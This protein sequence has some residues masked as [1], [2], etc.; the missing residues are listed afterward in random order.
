MAHDD[1]CPPEVRPY[2]VTASSSDGKGRPDPKV[3]VVAATRNDDHGGNQLARTQLFINGLAEQAARFKLPIELVLV[4]WN[5]PSD[6]PPLAEAMSW[7]RSEWFDPKIIV[8]PHEVHEGFPHADGLP[9]FQMIAK[10]VGIRRASAP[11]ALATNIDI[12]LSDELF[13]SFRESLKP[14]A[15]YRVDRLDVEA[16]LDR[17]PL[18]SPAECRALPW[19][20]AHRQD[21]AHYP[22][23][24]RPP[25]FVSARSRLNK[26][27]WDV[28]HGGSLPALFTW[29]CGDFTL[30]SR[31]I[32]GAMRGYPE[33][34]MYSF[35]L[36]S[37]VMV[38]AYEAGVEMV[39]LR[40]PMVA[41]HLEHGKGSGW[42]PEG[43]RHLFDR[44]DAAGV[45]YLTGNRYDSLARGIFAKKKD[46]YPFN[47]PDWG[48]ASA[49]LKFVSPG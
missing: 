19:L 44:L 48:L 14:N 35:H 43:A 40:P 42:T 29:G 3:S 20:R 23:G 26:T 32:W 5:P 13:E 38:L 46:F 39:T 31:E 49:D 6:R 15:M 7:H 34:P 4:E 41:F 18:P 10:N 28:L 22:D 36:D 16:D 25:W 8:V 37:L 24:R 12:L 45:P 1:R 9:L 27:V 47:G 33:W 30:A 21:G 17:M 2:R 11:F